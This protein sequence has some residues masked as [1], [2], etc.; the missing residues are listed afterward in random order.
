MGMVG[1]EEVFFD[2]GVDVG[3]SLGVERGDGEF[4]DD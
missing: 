1:D 4:W 3:E 2:G